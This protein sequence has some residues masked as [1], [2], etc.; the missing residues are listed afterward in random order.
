MVGAR[1]YQ[2]WWMQQATQSLLLMAPSLITPVTKVM[3]SLTITQSCLYNAMVWTGTSLIMLAQVSI[4]ISKTR[5]DYPDRS[6]ELN[7]AVIFYSVGTCPLLNLTHASWSDNRNRV[8]DVVMFT[9]DDGYSYNNGTGGVLEC[10]T[11]F[12]WSGIT[13]GCRRTSVAD[14][15]FS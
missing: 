15:A 6:Q 9:C 11:N 3:S 12:R 8:G 10:Q 5:D 14:I 7:Y 13:E 2:R 1:L 4:W